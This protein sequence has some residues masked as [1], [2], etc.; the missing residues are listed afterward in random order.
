MLYFFSGTD[1]EKAR[2][3]MNKE[4]SRVAKKEATII[5]VSDAN[6]PADLTSSLQGGGMFAQDRVVVLE[7]VLVN[8]D[9]RTIVLDALSVMKESKEKFFMF[10]EK[11]DAATR[12]QIEKYAEESKR[13]D[14]AKKAERGNTIFALA[15]ALKRGDK[16]ALWISYQRELAGSAPEAVHGVLFWGAKQM[17]LTSYS[18]KEKEHAK[19]LVAELAELPHRARRRGEELEYA[20]ERFV[21]TN[22]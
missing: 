6:T 4:L 20:L 10:E 11:P 13:F 17:F 21:L 1:R 2:A 15:N 12:K 8:E 16:K 22:V 14:A 7:G 3:E 18:E 9:M 5:R 19:K